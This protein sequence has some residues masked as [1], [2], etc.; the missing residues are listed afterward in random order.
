MAHSFAFVQVFP[1]LSRRQIVLT[2]TELATTRDQSDKPSSFAI[3]RRGRSQDCNVFT[4]RIPST[5]I[6]SH[7]SSFLSSFGS[8]QKVDFFVSVPGLRRE[9][10]SVR[11]VSPKDSLILC[12]SGKHEDNVAVSDNERKGVDTVLRAAAK[13]GVLGLA[14]LGFLGTAAPLVST[15][16]FS[17]P[18][19]ALE[20]QALMRQLVEVPVFTIVD[21]SNRPITC[22][23]FGDEKGRFAVFFLN[24]K[25]ALAKLTKMK[26]ENPRQNAKVITVSLD[27]AYKMLK[28]AEDGE[29]KGG[30]A[31]P[32]SVA[33]KFVP[34]T[35]QLKNA[36]DIL[37]LNGRKATHFNGTPI[38]QA[39]GLTMKQSNDTRQ[40]IPL[41]FAKED[42][43]SAWAE[44]RRGNPAMSP[45][46][47][48]EVGS[49]EELLKRMEESDSPEWARVVFFAP[50][51]SLDF[52]QFGR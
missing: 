33:A 45:Q 49:F 5:A 25:D 46:A 30:E 16:L 6:S 44:M 50:K 40:Y 37:K 35:K 21:A 12:S 34:T 26:K 32:D 19:H 27:K 52:V 3:Q 15:V 36:V 39:E 28:D 2:F 29:K 47:R 31:A 17:E 11:T 23:S 8:G 18:A 22:V 48:V 24:R 38:F 43:D 41:F 14:S 10:R 9:L 1:S 7:R 42:L 20:K 13:T 4:L 51:D